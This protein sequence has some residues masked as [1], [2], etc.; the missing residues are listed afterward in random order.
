[1]PIKNKS[2]DYKYVSADEMVKMMIELT[3]YTIPYGREDYFGPMLTKLGATEYRHER[4]DKLMA[5]RIDVGKNNK[6]MM[7][8]H[9][10]TASSQFEPVT[11][12]VTHTGLHSDGTTILGADN[13]SGMAVML[14]MIDHRVPAS[15]W[16]FVGEER[17]MIGS[18]YMAG[19]HPELF[20]GYTQCISIDRRGFSEIIIE[21]CGQACASENYAMWLADELGMRHEV[22]YEGAYTDSYAFRELIPECINIASG[23]QN[24]HGRDEMQDI[25]YITV[26]ANKMIQVNWDSAMVTRDKSAMDND[27]DLIED[28]IDMLRGMTQRELSA[29]IKENNLDA[30]AVMIELM[31]NTW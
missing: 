17:G 21:Q 26:L 14:Q 5:Y 28:T 1:M 18:S 3:A 12:I 22:S 15:Y 6:L 19:R 8:C 24:A 16:F 10:D 30:A 23:Y 4:D 7:A 29:W 25:D 20:T 9:L 2:N 13:K 27:M 31:N 11:H